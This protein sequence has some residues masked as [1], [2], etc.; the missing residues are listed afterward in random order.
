[1]KLKVKLDPTIGELI[2]NLKRSVNNL[3]F[4]WFKKPYKDWKQKN[5]DNKLKDAYRQKFERLVNQKAEHIRSL[6]L[7]SDKAGFKLTGM[8][9]VKMTDEEYKQFLKDEL[10]NGAI[11]LNGL[12]QYIS[13]SM[14]FEPDIVDIHNESLSDHTGLPIHEL[15]KA[16]SQAAMDVLRYQER[17]TPVLNIVTKKIPSDSKP[18]TPILDIAKLISNDEEQVKENITKLKDVLSKTRKK[19]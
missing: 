11:S 19:M 14:F 4:K 7:R 10:R 15:K 8:N 2:S 13:A 9:P 16:T 1:M 18:K 6:M 17:K 3:I 5:Q 12:K